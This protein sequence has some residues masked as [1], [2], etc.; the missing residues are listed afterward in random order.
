MNVVDSSGWLEYF[1]DAA[2]AEF[3]ASAIEDTDSLVVPTITLYEVFKRVSSQRGSDPAYVAV[4]QMRQGTVVDLDAN[5]AVSAAAISLE[6]RLP[7]ADA[8][9]LATSRA[10]EAVLWTQDEDFRD[11]EGVK[12]VAK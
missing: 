3:F 11:L 10:Y 1:A 8:V 12:Y 9:I 5:L 4:S 6:H 7:M 2:N